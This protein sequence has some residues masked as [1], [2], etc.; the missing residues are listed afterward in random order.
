[1]QF[2]FIAQSKSLINPKGMTTIKQKSWPQLS[3]V[4]DL[5]VTCASRLCLGK[6][7][8]KLQK[9]LADTKHQAFWQN[10]LRT[11][12]TRKSTHILQFVFDKW[13]VFNIQKQMEGNGEYK[14]DIYKVQNKKSTKR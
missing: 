12:K 5:S 11:N 9:P 14:R 6:R 4:T 1:M 8:K 13:V 3:K 7:K 2:F 10:T